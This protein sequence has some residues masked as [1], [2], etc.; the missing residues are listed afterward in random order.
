MT[1]RASPSDRYFLTAPERSDADK[2][3]QRLPL[4]PLPFGVSPDLPI[5]I[6]SLPTCSLTAS[7]IEFYPR[8]CPISHCLFKLDLQKGCL[9]FGRGLCSLTQPLFLGTAMTRWRATGV[10]KS[11]ELIRLANPGKSAPTQMRSYYGPA[12]LVFSKSRLGDGV[13]LRKLQK[14]R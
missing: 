8:A 11:P 9:D 3:S 12:L 5:V 7:I 13:P 2:F 14:H 10:D 4:Q 6:D 1:A